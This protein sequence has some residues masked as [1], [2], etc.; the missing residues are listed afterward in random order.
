MVDLI[1]LRP[2][3]T[4]QL[5]SVPKGGKFTVPESRAAQ[6]LRDGTAALFEHKEPKRDPMQ[7]TSSSSASPVAQVSTEQTLSE[8]KRG[9][10]PKKTDE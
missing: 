9:R 6:Y 8:S 4:M 1:A 3:N 7:A 2:L 5:G 10:K